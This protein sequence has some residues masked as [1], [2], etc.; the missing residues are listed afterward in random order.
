[1]SEMDLSKGGHL[2]TISE[3]ETENESRLDPKTPE[4]S[5]E[6]EISHSTKLYDRFEWTIRDV[7]A[8]VS[9][10]RLC[11]PEFWSYNTLLRMALI[12][13]KTSSGCHLDLHLWC[14]LT[15]PGTRFQVRIGMKKSNGKDAKRV[16]GET[17]SDGFME[18][19]KLLIWPH[20]A[21][22]AGNFK[23]ISNARLI[24]FCELYPLGTLRNTI[25]AVSNFTSK[26]LYPWICTV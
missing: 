15:S 17:D 21:L 6:G 1:M 24:I 23:Y 3:N 14:H 10:G 16:S 2:P 18:V 13:K 8:K 4:E 19:H 26:F 22:S 20:G 11:S 9:S 12:K 25:T 5:L 7:V